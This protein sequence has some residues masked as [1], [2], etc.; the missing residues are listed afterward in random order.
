MAIAKARADAPRSTCPLAC[1]LDL[2]GDRWTLLVLRDLFAG[3]QYFDELVASEERIATNVLSERL[4]RLLSAGLVT[5]EVCAENRRRKRY[6][7]T[8]RGRGFAPVL[9][10]IGSWGLAHLKDTRSRPEVR[11][12]LLRENRE[13]QAKQ[14]SS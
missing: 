6:T 5:V 2:V 8:E 7:L 12:A 1:T 11:A 9:V 3:K 10:A 13:I 4:Q 14:R